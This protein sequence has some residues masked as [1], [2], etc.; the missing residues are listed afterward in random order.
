MKRFL[1]IVLTCVL[2]ACVYGIIHDQITARICVQYFTVFHPDLFGTTDPTLLG[3]TWGVIA[4]W[5]VGLI[6][7]VPVAIVSRKANLRPRDLVRPLAWLAVAM[8]GGATI[9]GA[10]GWLAPASLVPMISP[11]MAEFEPQVQR[12]FM[13]ALFAHNASYAL[14]FFGGLIVLIWAWRLPRAAETSA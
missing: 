13:S 3:L 7:G 4:T 14:G 10:A 8:F 5:W 2:F 1:A 12:R 11:P 6:L 9:A